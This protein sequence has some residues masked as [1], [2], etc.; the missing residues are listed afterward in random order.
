MN[1]N[2][3]DQKT[4]IL[5]NVPTHKVS[6][7]AGYNASLLPYPKSASTKNCQKIAAAG[8]VVFDVLAKTGVKFRDED[9]GLDYNLTKKAD[10]FGM[11]TTERDFDIH[12][13]APQS[14]ATAMI[15][16]EVARQAER[17]SS[18]DERF[19]AA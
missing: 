18:N 10:A 15:V 7:C 19:A 6:V 12:Q 5:V 9:L 17:T 2:K 3:P 14:V 1:P 4:N 13:T 11:I 16:A 8:A